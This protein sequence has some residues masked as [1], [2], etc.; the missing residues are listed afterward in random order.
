MNSSLKPLRVIID[1]LRDVKKK[2][3]GMG[4]TRQPATTTPISSTT[5]AKNNVLGDDPIHIDIT[6]FK[7]LILQEKQ[8]RRQ[9]RLC[10]YCGEPGHI[11]QR[12]PNKRTF[13]A[14]SIGPVLTPF[15]TPK[16]EDVQSQ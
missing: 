9:N 4:L 15:E 5:S 11:A 6:Q 12:C 13:K 3:F 7:P 2:R 10:M 16:N 14:R 8:R 1:Y